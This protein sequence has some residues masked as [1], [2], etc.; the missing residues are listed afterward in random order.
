MF[1]KLKVVH[2]SIMVSEL[3]TP[4]ILGVDFLQQHGLVLDFS[5]I[6]L[7]IMP[8]HHNSSAAVSQINSS[9]VLQ[10]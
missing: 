5:T 7:S 1:D 4:A 9:I 10:Q 3:I 6:P 2:N 8:A